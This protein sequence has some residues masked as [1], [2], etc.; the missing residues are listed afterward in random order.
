MFPVGCG[1]AN[2]ISLTLLYGYNYQTFCLS[3]T[4]YL[5]DNAHHH[6]T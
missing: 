3:Y 6:M 2:S 4:S 5:N 1:E